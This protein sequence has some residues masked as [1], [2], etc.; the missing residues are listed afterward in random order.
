MLKT[1]IGQIFNL[2]FAPVASVKMKIIISGKE[3]EEC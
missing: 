1:C 2:L 3:K